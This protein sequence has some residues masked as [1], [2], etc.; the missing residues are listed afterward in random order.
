MND[1]IA[2][3]RKMIGH[4]TLLTVGCGV[5][6]ENDEGHILLQHRTDSNSWCIPG[7][8]MELGETVVETA[9]REV[10]EETG[11]KVNSPTLFGIYSKDAFAEYRNG[12]RV[13]SVQII[14]RAHEFE[15]MLKQSG[16]ESRSHRF[17]DKSEIPHNLAQLQ[18]EFILDWK[19]GE[20]SPVIK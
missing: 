4:E 19:N 5:I 8:T 20:N 1:Y 15:G 13:F 3:M 18:S 12:D 16:P 6:I 10:E 7:G 9:L 2:N 14:F 11:L 17:F